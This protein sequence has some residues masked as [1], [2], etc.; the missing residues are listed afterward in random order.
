MK[1]LALLATIILSGCAHLAVE[2]YDST[3]LKAAKVA[4]RIPLGIATLGTSEYAIDWERHGFSI[5]P[6]AANS[7]MLRPQP[8][9]VNYTTPT[10]RCYSTTLGN[11]TTTTCR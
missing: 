8:Q 6:A 10:V 5:D 9:P 3:T 7:I 2:P 11:S 1:R 4:V